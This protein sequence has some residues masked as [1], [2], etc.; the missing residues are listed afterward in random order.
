MNYNIK[1]PPANCMKDGDRDYQ[2][3]SKFILSRCFKHPVSE[4]DW[5]ED[6]EKG[7]DS[8]YER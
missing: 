1:V 4:G 8:I 3:I 7:I 6:T 5:S 2:R